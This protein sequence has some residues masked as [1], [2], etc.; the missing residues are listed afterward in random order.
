MGQP[1][2][3]VFV[4]FAC[5]LTK[6]KLG[7]IGLPEEEAKW[8]TA[9]AYYLVSPADVGKWLKVWTTGGSI[10]VGH[11]QDEND[12]EVQVGSA[13]CYAGKGANASLWISWFAR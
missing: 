11:E 13:A 4:L 3:S 12:R 2:L 10:F 6:P 8:L 7:T 1:F 9:V 5:Q